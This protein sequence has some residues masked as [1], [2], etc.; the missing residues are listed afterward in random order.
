VGFELAPEGDSTSVTASVEGIAEDE[1]EAAAEEWSQFLGDLK[2]FVETGLSGREVRQPMLGIMPDQLNA[3]SAESLGVPVETGMRIGG[4]VPEGAAGESGLEKDDVIVKIDDAEITDWPSLGI[5]L[6]AHSAGD[7]VNVHI[8]RGG[9]EHDFAV[10]LK[11][12]EMPEVPDS[13]DEIRE[14]Q[15][16]YVEEAVGKIRELF[17]GVTEAEAEHKP[18]ENEWS[19]K[20]VL[21]HLSLSER[22]GS[23]W[24]IRVYGDGPLMEWPGEGAQLLADAL[25][26]LPLA[27]LLDRFETDVRDY[28]RLCTAVLAQDLTPWVRRTIAGS[29]HWGMM[30]V[31]D[32]VGQIKEAIESARA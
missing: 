1:L 20:E 6:R 24:L 8:W 5:A 10:T 14:G 22:F 11:T 12:R 28:E 4:L 31:D 23:D 29:P 19:A 3:E 18:G 15:R 25:S 26:E 7:T 9:D 17:E 16:Q 13:L 21:V 2:L 30:H 27:D 32:H